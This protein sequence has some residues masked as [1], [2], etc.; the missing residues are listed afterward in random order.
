MDVSLTLTHH[1]CTLGFSGYN[2]SFFFIFF[3]YSNLYCCCIETL[4]VI[5]V[6]V[7]RSK[8]KHSSR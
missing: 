8:I 6:D 3:P 2:I 5:T 7:R 4:S 1:K